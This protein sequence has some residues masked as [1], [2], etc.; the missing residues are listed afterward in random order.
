MSGLLVQPIIGAVA[1]Q[2]K[3]KWGRRRPI[4]IIGSIIVALSL[5]V[6]GFTKELVGMFARPEAGASKTAT[7][8]VAVLAIYIVDFAINA[9]I[10]S[11][12]SFST[13]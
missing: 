12:P 9:G 4:I 5:L 7:I 11:L 6:L 13:S 10:V 8:V 1:D 2:S 3:S